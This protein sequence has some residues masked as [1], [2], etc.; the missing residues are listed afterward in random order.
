MPIQNNFPISGVVY[1]NGGV[2]PYYGV[3][4]T[5]R[6]ITQKN[7]QTKTTESDGSFSFNLAN[8]VGGY[9]NGDSLKLEAR[10]GSF[11]ATANLTVDTG[12]PGI[13]TSLTL[14]AE[15]I[16]DILDIQRLKEELIIFFRKNLVDP[17]SRDVAKT[18]TLSGTGTKVKFDLPDKT[19][20]FIDSITVDGVH[21]NNYADYYVNYND[22]L[23]LS[24]PVVYF[25]SP[26]ANGSIIEIKYYYGPSW[27]FA[28]IPRVDLK[29]DSYPR[30]NVKFLSFRT[31]EDGLGALGNITD[32]LGSVQ[33]WSASESELTSLI[34]SA[35]T[36]IMQNKKNFHYFIFIEP[37]G[38]SPVLVAPNREE[39]II[40]QSTDFLI[41]NRLEII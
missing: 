41:L 36:L 15:S 21:K 29:I 4:V 8:F 5:L 11:Y 31:R 32:V 9:S 2:A 30:V 23:S 6:N 18:A 38:V 28:D 3:N 35:R 37:Q 10:L 19:V 14:G 40:T 1:A 34:N 20:K 26:P 22:T 25:L 17:K 12:L 33:V 24:N 16:I 7:F 39:K 13:D 27:I